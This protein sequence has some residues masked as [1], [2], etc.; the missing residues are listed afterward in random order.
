MVRAWQW[1]V[2]GFALAFLVGLASIAM[3]SM[4]LLSHVVFGSGLDPFSQKRGHLVF[5]HVAA[6]AEHSW[7]QIVVRFMSVLVCV[8]LLMYVGLRVLYFC[9]WEAYER[10]RE[11]DAHPSIR[12]LTE[13]YDVLSKQLDAEEA[14]GEYRRKREFGLVGSDKSV[15]T[16]DNAVGRRVLV[17]RGAE[18]LWA[19]AKYECAEH[20]E[21]GWEAIVRR[22]ENIQKRLIRVEFLCPR[23]LPTNAL[24]SV[25][26]D[27]IPPN[28]HVR[29]VQRGPHGLRTVPINFLEPL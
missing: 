9:A 19:T 10:V 21:R 6:E 29:S 3:L 22:V 15:L 17:L 1:H 18:E 12:R 23:H 16:L 13:R 24:A 25:G 26:T 7:P 20:D 4:L 14:L 27:T 28:G 8:V 2:A 5:E 11:G